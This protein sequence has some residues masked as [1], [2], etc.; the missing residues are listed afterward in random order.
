M[1]RHVDIISPAIF[2]G[3]LLFFLLLLQN[4]LLSLSRASVALARRETFSF[5]PY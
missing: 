4:G 3:P 2:R 1:R 5:S